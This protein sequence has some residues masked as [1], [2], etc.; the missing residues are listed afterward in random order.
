MIYFCAEFPLG[1]DTYY[2]KVV[3]HNLKVKS[4]KI[5]CNINVGILCPHLADAVHYT[6]LKQWSKY[7][8]YVA[9]ILLCLHSIKTHPSHVLECSTYQQ[10]PPTPSKLKYGRQSQG[11][12]GF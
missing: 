10:H 9:T 4:Y 12:W 1:I 7:R 11:N 2:T 6:S 8:F 3:R 5:C